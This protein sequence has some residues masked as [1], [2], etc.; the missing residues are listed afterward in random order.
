MIAKSANRPFRLGGYSQVGVSMVEI[1]VALALSLVLMAGVGQIYLGSKQT[2]RLQ[3]GQ[4]R[5]QENARYALD[6]L[7]K[8][9]R[10]AGSMGCPSMG[11]FMPVEQNNLFKPT[12]LANVTAD[13]PLLSPNA[14][15]AGGVLGPAISGANREPED[16]T[17]SF[18]NPNPALSNSLDVDVV[19]GTDAI[20]VM[21]AEACGGI[22]T[23]NVA[24]VDDAVNPANLQANTTCDQAL[25]VYLISDCSKAHIFRM[26]NGATNSNSSLGTYAPGSE[27]M[28]FRAYT[29]YIRL[30]PAGE[31]ALYRFDN[32][33]NNSEELVEGIEDMQI[34]YGVD[35][36]GDGIADVY[37]KA[38]DIN[39]DVIPRNQPDW[40]GVVGVR[41][42]LRIRS[43]GYSANNLTSKPNQVRVF[44]GANLTD[45]RLVKRFSIS[46]QLRK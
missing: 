26:E 9:I 40:A 23:A 19:K 17:T 16:Q 18:S 25:G 36:S 22:T 14:V 12:I 4:S 5:L 13:H 32:S 8:D 37:L 28:R 30:N 39:A 35:T 10:K 3:D 6:T 33:A 21:F 7:S 2:Y 44:N 31:P 45:S 43:V 15:V 46:I 1:M 42:D 11:Y 34:V 41:I 24:T 38:S 27:V 20:T 29:Y